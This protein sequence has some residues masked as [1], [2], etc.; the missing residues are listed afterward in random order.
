[1]A[2]P[3]RKNEVTEEES[4]PEFGEH[5]TDVGES[6]V[7]AVGDPDGVT[8]LSDIEEMVELDDESIA[9]TSANDSKYSGSTDARKKEM[10]RKIEERQELKMLKDELGFDDFDLE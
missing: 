1:M 6:S 7:E 2:R 8:D 9:V 10:R 5:M 4:V 3:A